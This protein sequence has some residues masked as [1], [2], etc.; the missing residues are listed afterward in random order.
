MWVDLAAATG[1]KDVMG[2]Y[3]RMYNRYTPNSSMYYINVT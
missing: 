1:V 2:A 3:L